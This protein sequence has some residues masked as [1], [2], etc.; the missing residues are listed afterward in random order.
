MQAGKLAP[1]HFQVHAPL[2]PLRGEVHERQAWFVDLQPEGDLR[3][4][5]GGAGLIGRPAKP[6][7]DGEWAVGC[8][9]G[10]SLASSSVGP[11]AKEACAVD[12][13]ETVTEGIS[14]IA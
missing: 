6:A 13:R 10:S 12:F 8:K 2:P 11:G 1:R 3:F 14:S 7:W 4:F 9:T 5:A